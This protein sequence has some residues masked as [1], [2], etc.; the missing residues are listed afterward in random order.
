MFDLTHLANSHRLFF[1]NGNDISLNEF[2]IDINHYRAKIR[3]FKKAQSSANQLINTPLKVVLY[4]SDT[5]QF[6]IRLFALSAESIDVYFPSNSQ[7]QTLD[8]LFA[9]TDAFSGELGH[10]IT[11]PSIE[12]VDFERKSDNPQLNST[13]GFSWPDSGDLY[14]STSGSTGDAK[15]IHKSWQQINLEL[16]QLQNV[17]N[18]KRYEKLIA[19][20]SHQHIY[21]LLFRLLWPLSNGTLISDTFEYPEHVKSALQSDKKV[22]LISSPAF[23]KRLIND[24]V[25][26]AYSNHFSYI[27]SSG[28]LLADDI[29]IHLNQQLDFPIT[30]VYGSTETG[31]IAYRQVD[32]LPASHWQTFKGI[33][34]SVEAQSKRLILQSPWV[35]DSS[36]LLD[37]MGELTS[38]T[39]FTLQGRIDRNVKLEEKRVNLSA[40]EQVANEHCWINESRILLKTGKRD[41][42]FAV[43]SLTEL[44]LVK[45]D[46]LTTIA[47]TREIK[48]HLL[49]KFE[50]VCL[51][52]KWRY[53]TELPYNSQ[54]KLVQ[55][56]LEKLFE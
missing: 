16:A 22:A 41:V 4:H 1:L 52:K 30:Q 3:N 29:A 21:G 34:L 23:L 43:L 11:F 56:E 53:L 42:L 36:M 19:T 6:S 20:V 9:T 55:R 40:M 18:I 51:P 17:F 50:L 25:L 35:S 28:G 5:Y 12:S 10:E 44:G 54:G 24:N 47:F 31:G 39:E 49:G 32:S 33:T 15:I 8:S 46:E 26:A 38:A 45:R 14:F 7:I 37:D 27:F 48:N 13:S 2:I